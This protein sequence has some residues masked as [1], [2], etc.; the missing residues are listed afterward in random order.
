MARAALL[1]LFLPACFIAALSQAQDWP[2]FRGPGGNGISKDA[3]APA[4]WDSETNI[5]WKIEVPGSGWSAPVVV[6]G[7]VFITTAVPTDSEDAESAHRF[8]VHCFELASGKRLWQRVSVEGK[9]RVPKHKD[10]TYASETPVTDGERIIAYFGMTG[11]FCYDLDGQLLWQKDL[12]AFKMQGD[13]G[14]ASSPALHDGLVFIQVDNEEESFLA[15]F[16]ATSGDERWRVAREEKST[17]CSPII[18]KNNARTELVTGGKAIRSYDPQSGDLLWQLS[19]GDRATSASPAGNDDMLIVGGRGLF[20][21]RAGAAGDITPP[22]GGT[23]SEGLLWA[24]ESGA[25]GMASPLIYYDFVYILDRR[26]GIVNCYAADTGKL[27]YKERL[28]GSREFWASPWACDSK[29][30]CSD[31][32]GAT[33]VLAPGPEFKLIGANQLAGRF[34]ASSAVADSSLLLRS[35]GALHCIKNAGAA[36]VQAARTEAAELPAR[37]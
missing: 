37:K 12:G 3:N 25:P 30:F 36:A 33:H 10:N 23:T 35:A 4:T 5:R 26:G 1:I 11:L 19:V 13:W 27:A 34:W 22:A 32:A 31:D 16:D 18:W 2:Q 9:P 20:A 14:A 8:E 24:N 28:P 15:A 7:K 21:V 29:I 6:K 17:W